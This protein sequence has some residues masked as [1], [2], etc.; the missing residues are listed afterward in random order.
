MPRRFFPGK[1]GRVEF[2]AIVK[3]RGSRALMEVL[4]SQAPQLAALQRERRSLRL[5]QAVTSSRS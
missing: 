2:R 4:L 1:T 5:S 3:L